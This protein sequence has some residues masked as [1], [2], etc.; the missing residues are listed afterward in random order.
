MRLYI[1][2]NESKELDTNTSEIKQLNDLYDLEIVPMGLNQISRI[3]SLRPSAINA[4][5]HVDKDSILPFVE[6]SLSSSK[7]YV[8]RISANE[9]LRITCDNEQY[10]GN[11]R[12]EDFSVLHKTEMEYDLLFD[13]VRGFIT[14]SKFNESISR[15]LKEEPTKFFM[16]NNG[17]TLTANDIIAEDTNAHKKVKISINDFQI[18]NGGQTLRTLHNFKQQDADNIEKYL[19]GGELL[20]RVF[21]TSTGTNVRNKIAEYTNSQNAISNIDLK[22]L[23]EEQIQIEQFLDEHNIVYARKSGDTGI[24]ANKKYIHKISMEKFGQILFAIQGNPE[25]ASN[26]KKHIFEKY[27]D[28]VFKESKKESKFDL[29][30]SSDYVLRYFE[31]K[32]E[33]EK[34][35]IYES[36]DQRVF[37]VLFIDNLIDLTTKEK[38]ELVENTLKKFL[39]ADKQLNDVRKLLQVKFREM[40]VK[41]V[42]SVK[43]GGASTMEA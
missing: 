33:Y 24:S 3:M 9:L 12:M 22:S 16:Y 14:R 25:K 37:F 41:E 1:V 27:Y 18:V 17:L 19:S 4:V 32:R 11:Y 28:S 34:I 42:E 6:N 15:T 36:S 35:G 29:S 39:P 2:S 31:I 43:N 23:S 30:K 26:Q 10:R 21:K 7:S 38:I 5:I 13:N 40:L 20:I 8:I